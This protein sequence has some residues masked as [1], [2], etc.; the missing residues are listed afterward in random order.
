[1]AAEIEGLA[2]LLDALKAL[3]AEVVSKSGGPVKTA[4]RKAANVIRDE[5]RRRV[6]Y[7]ASKPGPHVRDNI[8]SQRDSHPERIGL[9]GERYRVGVRGGAKSYANTR[10][11]RQKGRTGKKYTTVGTTYWWRFLEFGTE[12]MHAK[13]FLRPA[14]ESKRDEALAVIVSE[15]TDG[16]A[17]AAAKVKRS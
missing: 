10:R 11:N 2:G 14:F 13:P 3:P 4:M 7:D 15:L 6:A 12:K 9:Q 5:A 1:M 8:V 16:I 17:K